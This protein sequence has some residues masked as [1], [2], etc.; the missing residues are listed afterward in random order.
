MLRVQSPEHPVCGFSNLTILPSGTFPA[1]GAE[2]RVRLKDA[3]ARGPQCC[4]SPVTSPPIPA[5][6][7]QTNSTGC[8]RPRE[9]QGATSRCKALPLSSVPPCQVALSAVIRKNQ[10]RLDLVGLASLSPFLGSIESGE[11]RG[12]VQLGKTEK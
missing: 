2:E 4:L 7:Q 3:S 1:E 10:Q 11:A 8:P 9:R 6:T 12:G 5:H